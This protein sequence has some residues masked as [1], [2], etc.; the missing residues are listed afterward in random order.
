MVEYFD[1]PRR[2]S[3]RSSRTSPFV[4]STFTSRTPPRVPALCACTFDWLPLR[5]RDRHPDHHTPSRSRCNS[6]MSIFS[7]LKNFAGSVFGDGAEQTNDVRL[8]FSSLMHGAL[9][10]LSNVTTM[11]AVV[12]THDAD[13]MLHQ[14]DNAT[15]NWD[16][17]GD[18]ITL[19][20][21]PFARSPPTDR[22]SS[23]PIHI[24]L[25]SPKRQARSDPRKRR[26]DADRTRDSVR[27]RG[28]ADEKRL[29]ADF[30]C[31]MAC[32]AERLS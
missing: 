13:A 31:V 9:D 18:L 7:Q 28:S 16:L 29:T 15:T 30:E 26:A 8:P 24:D 21:N 6:S 5:Y 27:D 22:K 20:T 12:P 3:V 11:T 23:P 19:P 32:T 10:R 25:S 17:S 1:E 14:T 2:Q 4:L